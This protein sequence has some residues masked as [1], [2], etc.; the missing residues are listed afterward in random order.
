ML[1]LS[2]VEYHKPMSWH[3][4]LLYCQF[5]EIDG[6]TGWRLPTYLELSTM[7]LLE[8]HEDDD[9]EYYWSSNEL[10]FNGDAYALS[11]YVVAAYTEDE[12]QRT[13]ALKTY[14]GNIVF[15]VRVI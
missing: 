7:P 1:E 4:A 13:S 11:M 6:K 9:C 3:D 10:V 14:A 15:P 5:L 12:S 2:P 8:P